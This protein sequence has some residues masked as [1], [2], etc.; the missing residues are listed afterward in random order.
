MNEQGRERAVR[1]IRPIAMFMGVVI[2][3]L[4]MALRGVVQMA[5]ILSIVA[6]PALWWGVLPYAVIVYG[7]GMVVG[8]IRAFATAPGRAI[9][10]MF[11]H[12]GLRE[13]RP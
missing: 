6:L 2:G 7:G 8:C 13:D 1:S 10:V 4:A 12:C 9:V 5:P 3:V 11:A